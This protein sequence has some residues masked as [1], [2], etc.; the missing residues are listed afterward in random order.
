MTRLR[1]SLLALALCLV[2]AQSAHAVVGGHNVPNGKYPYV[3]YI[4]I[5]SAFACTGTLVTP[6]MVLTAG[7]CSS[8]TPG[9]ASV[10]VGQPGQLITVS[11]NSNKPGAGI[12]PAVKRTIVNPNYNFLNGDSYD[13]SLIELAAPV[14]LPT[15]QV[16]GKG[17]ESLWAPGTSATIAGFGTTCESCDAAATMQEAQVPITTDA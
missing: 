4:T 7:H 1:F 11:L 6:T 14:N 12:H 15:V 17:E 8:I 2:P 3:A 5:D 10:P 13:A 16:A 9:M